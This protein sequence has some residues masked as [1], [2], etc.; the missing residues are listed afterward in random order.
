MFSRIAA[1]VCF[2][3]LPAI[4]LAQE[5]KPAADQVLL[6]VKVPADAKVFID[7]AST[8]QT[9]TSREFLSTKL[10]KAGTYEV[11]AFWTEDG[12]EKGVLKTATFKL[13]ETVTVDFTK[14]APPPAKKDEPKKPEEKKPEKKKPEEKKPDVKKEMKKP[15]EKKPEVKK[16]MKKPE[17]KKPEVKKPEVK[18]PE[19][20]KPEEKKPEV[21]PDVL[22]K[23]K[24]EEKADKP[25]KKEPEKKEPEKKKEDPDM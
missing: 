15:E 9:G 6:V 25:A 16:E 5:N 3:V 4:S 18:K 8:K 11:L 1:A 17:E 2:L 21:N 23:P 10:T 24:A 13:G 7:G 22:P 12:K 14:D 19:V 20:K